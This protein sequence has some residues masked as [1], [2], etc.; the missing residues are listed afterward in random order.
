MVGLFLNS[1]LL[2]SLRGRQEAG[3]R[4]VPRWVLSLCHSMSPV[5]SWALQATHGSS[6]AVG[7]IAADTAPV[8]E[9]RRCPGHPI[10]A[11]IFRSLDPLRYRRTTL[12]NALPFQGPQGTGVKV[13]KVWHAA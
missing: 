7:K 9:C 11:G 3:G 10:H 8:T 13:T 2:L 5:H 6:D 1:W 4:R 12:G